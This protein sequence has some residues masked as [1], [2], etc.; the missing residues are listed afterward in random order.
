MSSHDQF[1]A[2]FRESALHR[3]DYPILLEAWE[4]SRAALV[5]E[6]P[7]LANPTRWESSDNAWNNAI[8]ACKN[9]IEAAGLQVK[10]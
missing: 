1:E 10:P 2:W 6:L 5:V 4:A 7:D 3:A 9:A 8:K